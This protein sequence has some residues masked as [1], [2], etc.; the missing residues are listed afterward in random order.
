MPPKSAAL[1]EEAKP[2]EYPLGPDS[3]RREGIPQG[4]VTKHIWKSTVFAGTTREYYV[5]VPR[6]VRSQGH[7]ASC[8]ARRTYELC[9]TSVPAAVL[10]SRALGERH[11]GKKRL[12]VLL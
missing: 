4:A 3:T 10:R 6:P 5:Y 8:E 11:R 9:G 2:K 1:A 7:R 12:L